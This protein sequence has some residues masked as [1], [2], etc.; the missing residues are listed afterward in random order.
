MKSVRLF[1]AKKLKS[2]GD[3]CFYLCMLEKFVGDSLETIGIESFQCSSFLKEINLINVKKIGKE[4]F[5]ETSLKI[6]K[7]NYIKKLGYGQFSDLVSEVR[8]IKMKSLK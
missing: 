4:A 7:N 2:V 3:S 6:I 8:K 1:I 5:C